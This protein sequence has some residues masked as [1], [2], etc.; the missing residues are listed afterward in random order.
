ME[1]EPKTLVRLAA[2]SRDPV[3]RLTSCRDLSVVLEDIKEQ[4]IR[5]G[6]ER[7]LSWQT[8]GEALGMTKQGAHQ[9]LRSRERGQK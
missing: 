2:E 7:E 4:A 5:Y 6:R 9:F 3:V 1:K 8:I